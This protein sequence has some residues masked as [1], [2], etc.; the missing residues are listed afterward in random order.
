MRALV[1]GAFGFAG[2]HLVRLLREK[3]W[4]VVALAYPREPDRG[5]SDRPEATRL[6]ADLLEPEAVARAVTE[7]QP[8]A[9]FH[10]AA[11]SNPEQS[12]TE[13]RRTLETNVIGTHNL[14]QATLASG[15]KPRVLLVGSTQQYGLVPEEDQPIREEHPQRPRSP[16]GVSK[17]A[18]ELLGLSFFYA[19]GLPV[20]LVRAFNHAG[21]GQDPSYVCSSFARQV[22]EIETGRREPTIRVGNLAVRRD[23]SDVR[24]VVRAYVAVVERGEPGQPYN[25]CRGEAYSIRQILDALLNLT[26]AAVTIEVDRN[27]YHSVDAPLVLGDNSKA[28]YELGLEPRLSLK[29]TL[30]DL[31]DDWRARMGSGSA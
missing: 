10:L 9:I 8:D 18:Q 4:T 11:F 15:A 12:W 16:Y 30:A 6:E 20:Y 21:P 1:T 19:E 28:R 2:R 31:L 26:S 23:F 14:L 13:S 5:G 22:V 3:D 17:A 25:I 24:D 29:Q 7:A 27:R